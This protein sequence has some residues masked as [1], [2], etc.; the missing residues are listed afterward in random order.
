[1]GTVHME[2]I[3]LGYIADT[4]VVAKLVTLLGAS[5]VVFF[6]HVINIHHVEKC[7]IYRV[8]IFVERVCVG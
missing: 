7:F 6:S 3:Q 2:V 1:M 5:N 8:V 4:S